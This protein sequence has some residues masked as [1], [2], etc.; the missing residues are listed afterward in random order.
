MRFT[1]RTVFS[2]MRLRELQPSERSIVVG[3]SKLK[4]NVARSFDNL[5]HPIQADVED[6]QNVSTTNEEEVLIVRHLDID[7]LVL[8]IDAQRRAFRE[9]WSKVTTKL[10][11]SH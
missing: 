2:E 7:Y 5:H 9:F 3:Q 6:E 10:H 4:R 8:F 1:Y 11:L